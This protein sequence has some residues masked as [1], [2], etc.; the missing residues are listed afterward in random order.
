MIS[1]FAYSVAAG[2]GRAH[3]AEGEKGGESRESDQ[4]TH[5]IVLL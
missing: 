5:R 1:S 2:C 4:S 3:G